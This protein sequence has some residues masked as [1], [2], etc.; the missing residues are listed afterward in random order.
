MFTFTIN[1]QGEGSTWNGGGMSGSFNQNVEMGP[2]KIFC[3]DLNFN[4]L[5]CGGA[6]TLA[7][8]VV[9]PP[10][11]SVVPNCGTLYANL[12]E[13]NCCKDCP[14]GNLIVTSNFSNTIIDTPTDLALNKPSCV[15]SR[16]F[17]QA[18]N[19]A[20]AVDNNSSTSVQT[21]LE[22]NPWWEVDLYGNFNINTILLVSNHTG[23][24]RILISDT[25]FTSYDLNTALV[26]SNNYTSTGGLLSI[27][28]TGRFV[29]IYFEGTGQLHLS[30]VQIIGTS[31]S[32]TSPFSYTWNNASLG[33][34]PT[35][36]CLAPGTYQVQVQDNTTGCAVTETFQ[37]AN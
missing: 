9:A 36:E 31:H 4:L 3:G 35:P 19:S 15:S 6:S 30:D 20:Y 7:V 37:I 34:T 8:N 26:S 16:A 25:P 2:Y 5:A 12:S 24:Y 28:A 23:T 14:S 21:A 32:A 22:E 33:N 10:A 17:G 11:C 29:R 1:V 13:N 27:N 18:S